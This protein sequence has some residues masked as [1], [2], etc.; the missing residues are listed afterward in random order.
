MSTNSETINKGWQKTLTGGFE[1]DEELL[2]NPDYQEE[3]LLQL[4]MEKLMLQDDRESSDD[5]D[6]ENEV[7][8]VEIEPEVEEPKRQKQKQITDFFK[9]AV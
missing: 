4:G 5:E 7:E 2:G 6:D 3:L 1:F 9:T 8:V